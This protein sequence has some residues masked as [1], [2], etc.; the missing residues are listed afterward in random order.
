MVQ[1]LVLAAPGAKAAASDCIEKGG[2]ARCSK[3]EPTPWKYVLCDDAGSYVS[4]WVAWCYTLYENAQWNGPYASPPCGGTPIVLT[5]ALLVPKAEEFTNNLEGSACQAKATWTGWLSPGQT[6]D[7]WQC[8][9]GSPRYQNGIE[10]SNLVDMPVPCTGLQAGER[11]IGRRDR[12]V[13]CPIGYTKRNTSTGYE[14]Y[15]VPEQGCGVG[16][17]VQPQSGNKLAKETD[18]AASGTNPLM[19]V[20]SYQSFGYYRPLDG[21]EEGPAGF[22]DYWRM[23]Y[24]RRIYVVT[25]N[26][27]VMASVRR[28]DGHIKYFNAEGR[29][30]LNLGG[31]AETLEKLLDDTATLA[32]WRYTNA[33][34]QIETYDASGKL[35]SITNPSGLSQ[36][37]GYN[38]AGQLVSVTDPFGRELTF[39]YNGKGLVGTMTDPAGGAYRY[40]Y[41]GND[42]LTSVSYP[43]DTPSDETDNPKRIYHYEDSRF[44]HALT[45]I[46][47]ENGNRFATYTYD[48]QGRA[49]LS[50]HAGGAER[51]QLS[52]NADGTTTVT[53]AQGAVRHY[54]FE[55]RQG[56]IKVKRIRGGPCTDC[57]GQT[58]NHAYDANGNVASKTDFNGNVTHYLYD[59]TRNLETSRIEA[60]GKPE[61]R[62]TTTQWH[63]DF[64]LPVQ[65]DVFDRNDT[66][67]KRTMFT[68]DA[69]GRLLTRTETDTSSGESR[70][71]TNSYNALRLLG[72]VDGPRTDIADITGFDYDA[73]GNLIKTT[74]A[75]GH[76]TSVSQ[77]YAHGRPLS[78]TDPN[79][80]LTEL[81]YDAR[82]RLQRQSVDGQ[83]T[84]FSY[85]GAGNVTALTLPTGGSLRY[86]YDPAHRLTAIQDSTGNTI[87]YTLDAMG[88]RIKEEVTDPAGVLTRAHA[89]VYN[90]L[91]RLLKDIGGEG[92]ER[93][94]AYDANG[95]RLS[96]IDGRG[97]ETAF[98]F[99]A[100]NRLLASTD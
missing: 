100:L 68:Y 87:T 91:N 45:G 92:Q 11:I 90:S 2:L 94:Y 1:W 64:R 47:D 29:E 5:E 46:T 24:D 4:R 67:L 41:D 27:T 3:Q 42:N 66:H 99:D 51:V 82:G 54:A 73:Q 59:L 72:S 30:I 14:C 70:T 37:L 18:Y 22:G 75:L 53:D 58:Q 57:G 96:A 7:S 20:R 80:L 52:Y 88:N 56:V 76:E 12:E 62:T 50:E 39:A 35:I 79:G 10:T 98:A 28:P 63:A 60:V 86:T 8:W 77:H 17:P 49:I 16:N 44:P 97:H 31:P 40:S 9:S 34:D 26:P 89:R 65:I 74:N 6:L 69:A 38:T 36:T 21:S 83:I 84:S 71:T 55:T 95:N 93:S 23:S 19:L 85:D 33:Q 78:L 61:Q 13:Y 32:G 81:A 48:A 25:S 15:Q 43:D